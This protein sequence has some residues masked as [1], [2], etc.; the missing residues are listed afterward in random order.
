MRVL[1]SIR[2]GARSMDV[3]TSGCVVRKEVCFGRLELLKYRRASVPS[4]GNP[5][6]EMDPLLNLRRRTRS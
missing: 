5:V 3:V 2:D 4:L 1:S 6:D